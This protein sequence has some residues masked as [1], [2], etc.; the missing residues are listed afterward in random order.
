MKTIRHTGIKKEKQKIKASSLSYSIFLILLLGFFLMTLVMI[1][2]YN[3]IFYLKKQRMADLISNTNSVVN[4]GLKNNF[5]K[6]KKGEINNV[7]FS[8]KK[9]KWGLLDVLLYK[10]YK[11]KDT[12]KESLFIG[13]SKQDKNTLFLKENSKKINIGG[14]SHIEGVINIPFEDLN[15]FN[16]NG[17]FSDI[18][19]KSEIRKPM[20]YF[21][22]IQNKHFLEDEFEY[23]N[24]N[25]LT[26]KNSFFNKTIVLLNETGI[27]NSNDLQGNYLLTS[28]K[29]RVL[30]K[31]NNKFKNV[32]IKAE[33]VEIEDG[34]KGAIQ[35][36]ASKKIII[37]NEVVLKYPSIVHLK[38]ESHPVSDIVIGNKTKILGAIVSIS[39]KS[40]NKLKIGKDCSIAGELLCNKGGVEF[41]GNMHGVIYADHFFLDLEGANY[42]N[43]LFNVGLFKLPQNFAK[44]NLFSKTKKVKW[45]ILERNI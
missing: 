36:F 31:K 6:E 26:G 13:N 28:S 22:E 12:I 32:I 45:S 38:N 23:Q 44:I 9:Q 10:V 7:F 37:G 40:N 5:T 18:V 33:I 41:K 24:R 21:P 15:Y 25:S 2:S 42:E 8:L 20:R 35:I 43:T 39:N 27:L 4:I 34:F 1:K 14:I 11:G 16:Q 30:V 3:H 19:D 17:S 29:K